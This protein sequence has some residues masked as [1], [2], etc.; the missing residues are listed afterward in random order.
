MTQPS[1]LH[2]FPSSDANLMW[3]LQWLWLLAP[4]ISRKEK[5]LQSHTHTWSKVILA[6]LPMFFSLVNLAIPWLKMIFSALAH[7][8]L[9][10]RR[11][12]LV[13]PLKKE[14]GHGNMETKHSRRRTMTKQ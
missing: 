2:F 7:L 9:T 4:Q 8:L 11:N 10:P 1:L 13:E 5:P 12:D 3:L 6:T 14:I